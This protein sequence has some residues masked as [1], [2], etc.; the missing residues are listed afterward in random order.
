MWTSL[1]GVVTEG[2]GT[3]SVWPLFRARSSVTRGGL[4]STHVLPPNPIHA[5]GGYLLPSGRPRLPSNRREAPARRRHKPAR[6]PAAP[7]API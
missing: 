7:L 6:L 5:A 3:G 2:L 4:P 1:P